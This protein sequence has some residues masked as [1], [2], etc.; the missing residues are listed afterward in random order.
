METGV[1]QM[2]RY[3]IRLETADGT[4][5]EAAY[6]VARKADAIR[7]AKAWAKTCACADVV[8]VHVDDTATELGIAAFEV[9][10]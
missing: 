1:T 4:L 7:S 3:A 6:T 2:A 8:R 9:V 10:R 5:E